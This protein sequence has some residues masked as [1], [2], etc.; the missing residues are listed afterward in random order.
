MSSD[1]VQNVQ[2]QPTIQQ[3]PEELDKAWKA[4]RD[5]VL[6]IIKEAEIEQKVAERLQ[7]T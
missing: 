1:A 4:L 6:D 7:K 2:Q 3:Y 5:F